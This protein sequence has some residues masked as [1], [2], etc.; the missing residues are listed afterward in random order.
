MIFNPLAHCF[1]HLTFSI[2]YVLYE[3]YD[4][5]LLLI[6]TIVMNYLRGSSENNMW[7]GSYSYSPSALTGYLRTSR[8][9][10]PSGCGP[11]YPTSLFMWNLRLCL[12][13]VLLICIL[14]FSVVVLCLLVFPRIGVLVLLKILAYWKALHCHHYEQQ[15]RSSLAEII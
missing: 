12:R 1:L 3:G 5:E 2:T 8:S 4:R 7:V 13:F 11:G 14:R 10:S 9:R 15:S 6:V